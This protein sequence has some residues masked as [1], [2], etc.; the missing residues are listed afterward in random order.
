ML[1]AINQ[2][3]V[4]LVRST[5]APNDTT[6]WYKVEDYLGRVGFITSMSE[7]FCA[8]CNRLR[9]TADGK[10]KACLFGSAEVDLKPALREH[11]TEDVERCITEAIQGKHFALGGHRDMYHLASSENRPMI[12][13]GG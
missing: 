9:V 4:L 1:S 6:K 3:K 12:L 7:H 2:S 10:L 8:S 5:D 13:I 11:R